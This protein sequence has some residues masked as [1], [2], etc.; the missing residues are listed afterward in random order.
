ML[1]SSKNI[2]TITLFIILTVT[3]SS[4][5]QSTSE[6][7]INRIKRATVFIYQARNEGN[8]LIITCVST[9]T[10]VSYDGL[11]LTNAHSTAPDSTCNGD[12]IIIAINVDLNEPP[13]PKYRADIA[14]VDEGL[15]IALL[16]ITRELDGRLIA[17]GA[18][19]SLPFVEIGDSSEV[20]IDQNITVVGYTNIDNQPIDVTR[21]TITA[22]ISEPRGG[23]RSWFKTR[24]TIPGT[25]SGGG[26]Y[27]SQGQLIGIPTTAPVS[28]SNS[29]A[30]CKFIEDS[31]QDGFINNNDQCIPIG[32]FISSIRPSNFA[33]SL[34]RSASL[35]LNV[36]ILTIPDVRPNPIDPPA[37]SRL[38]F[39]P[40]VTN[41]LPSTVVG[42][43]PANT[44]SLYLF[45]DY[46]NM[47][48]ETVY[49]LRVTR[50]GVPDSIFSLPPI[51][52]S[53]SER[54]LWYIGSRDQP[55]ANG[56]YEFNLL[57]NGFAAGSQRVVIGGG[58]SVTPSF[59]NIV[60]GL[61][62]LQGNIL[63][64]GY[65][66]PTGSIASARFVY[67]N[68]A[69]GMNWTSLWYFNGNEVGRST[70]AW[71]GGPNGSTVANLRP[72][73]GLFPGT[74]RL[75]LYIENALSAT[76]DFVVAGAQEGPLPIIFTNARYTI[77]Q[78]P[79]EAL[80][81]PRVTSLPNSVDVLYALFDW[82]QIA[83]GTVWT[84]RW[85]V[86][87]DLF[88]ELTEPWITNESG[89]NFLFSLNSP[90]DGTYTMELLVNN[91]QIT[92]TTAAVGIGQLA[93]D[94]FAE[95]EGTPFGGV[96]IDAATQT[97]IP[98]VTVIL[99]SEDF[100]IEDFVWDQEQVFALA[101]TD[102]NGDFQFDRPLT[103]ETPYSLAI[104]ANGY[105]PITVDG[106]ELDEE[107]PNPLVI[108]VELIHD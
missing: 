86:D 67:A 91:L 101:T 98:N 99:I 93:I 87:G 31:N 85:L 77:A 38:F 48:S 83:P 62:D 13:I 39:S 64:N 104:E 4:I 40:S 43:L 60:F 29:D 17:E 34:I 61:L 66:L 103:L 47:T 90:P 71:D 15:D 20:T 5:A 14:Q 41:G 94:R 1:I 108:T 54:G 79:F 22:F 102:R 88:F 75:E 2:K 21:G 33:R 42:S 24:S 7:D 57:I 55:W 89:T 96:V 73:G 68:L 45:F 30:S 106:F 37:F 9:G 44:N 81:T 72:E 18:L 63:G 59:S 12:T 8:N 36:D 52:W 16:Q 105:L 51:R 19:P 10:I 28:L 23:D 35:E 65:V 69:D 25:M 53:G 74:Y 58:A 3:F 84:V 46:E 26:A 56:V 70:G 100:S 27:N 107:S 49:E 80:N 92:E 78:S 32:G 97:G 6:L 82:Q 76:A 95:A 50:D 11:I